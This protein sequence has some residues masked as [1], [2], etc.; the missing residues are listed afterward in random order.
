[1][2]HEN[3]LKKL[4]TL[5]L[6]N[7]L[8]ETVDDI[9]GLIDIDGFDFTEGLAEIPQIEIAIK[10]AFENDK[11]HD[12]YNE[13]WEEV[14][15]D[16]E[17]SKTMLQGSIE[18]DNSMLDMSF[19][20]RRINSKNKYYYKVEKSGYLAD[21]IWDDD[22]FFETTSDLLEEKGVIEMFKDKCHEISTNFDEFDED[23]M[24]E[25]GIKVVFYE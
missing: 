20:I 22:Y 25:N 4:I 5:C 9:D 8:I 18:H 3:Y 11:L 14:F 24:S 19:T 16:S 2:E 13:Y 15:L 10:W 17:L 1:M 6:E 7:K 23:V 21:G 12:F